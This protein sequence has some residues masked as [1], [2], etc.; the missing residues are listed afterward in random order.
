MKTARA[1]TVRI[2]QGLLAAIA[3][4]SGMPRDGH[5]QAYPLKPVRIVVPSSP[6]GGTDF[7]ARLLAGRLTESLGQPFIVENRA[8]AGTVLGNDVVAKSAPDGYTVLMA[9]SA[10]VITAAVQRIPYDVVRD[11]APISQAV[12]VPNVLVVHPSLPVK[13]VKEFIALARRQPGKLTA[14]SAG[15]GTSPHLSLVLLETMT[16]T[17]IL[18]VPYKGSGQGMIGL[19]GGEVALMFPS[20][21]SAVQQIKAGKLRALGVTTSQRSI[22]LP[23]VPTIAEAGV[24]GYEATQWFGLM[25][26]AGMPRTAIDVLYKATA[27]ALGSPEARKLLMVEG[28]EPVASRPEAFGQYIKAELTKW[29]A[30]VKAA[31]MAQ[32]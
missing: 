8:G 1:H 24:P 22:G 23:D 15:T 17:S 19:L 25:G 6:G 18:H 12:S 31:G 9:A 32:Q 21:P 5:A 20:V 11:F 27:E 13:T 14:G 26:P 4:G 3:F 2:V 28:A 30:V 16:G 10:L 29:A 7:T